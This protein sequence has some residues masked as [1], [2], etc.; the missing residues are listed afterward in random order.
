M[1]LNGVRNYSSRD[2]VCYVPGLFAHDFSI[3][4]LTGG[5]RRFSSVSSYLA[6]KKRY[7]LIRTEWYEGYV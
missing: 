2:Q 5:F 6:E 1:E 7:A 4:H 3:C